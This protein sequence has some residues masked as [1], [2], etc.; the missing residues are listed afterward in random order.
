MLHGFTLLGL[1]AMAASLFGFVGLI[2]WALWRHRESRLH[3]E[4]LSMAFDRA[5][6]NR[7]QSATLRDAPFRK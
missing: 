1:V 7:L 2:G 5:R 3:Q 6:A 4:R